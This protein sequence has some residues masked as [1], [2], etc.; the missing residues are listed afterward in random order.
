MNKVEKA[1]A[2]HAATFN[3]AQSVFLP[4]TADYGVDEQLA[5]KIATCFGTGAK[6]GNIC[7]AAS[8][9]SMTSIRTC[10]LTP[11]STSTF[12]GGCGVGAGAANSTM[13]SA[14]DSS[15]YSVMRPNNN[16]PRRPAPMA[17]RLQRRSKTAEPVLA[18]AFFALLFFAPVPFFFRHMYMLQPMRQRKK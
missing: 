15:G 14:K 6:C 13:G 4:Y 9:C 2:I 16:T 10:S 1:L 5:L 18:G 3:C 7:G 12:R 8:G 17:I 11:G